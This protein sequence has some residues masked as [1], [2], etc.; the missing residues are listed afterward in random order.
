MSQEKEISSN[1]PAVSFSNV[2]FSYDAKSPTPTI[3]GI[4]FDIHQGEYMCIVGSNGSGKSTISK[5]IV[6]L[7]KP[8]SGEIKIFG[9]ILNNLTIKSIRNNVGIIFQNPDNQFIGLTAEDDIAFGL[10]NNKINSTVMFDIITTAANIVNVQDL[11]KLNASR[12]SGGQKQRVAIASVLAMN[13]KVI[14]FDE[15]TSM[16]DPTSKVELNNLMTMLRDK[17][18]KTIIS[19]THDMEELLRADRVMVIK[20]GTVQKIGKPSEIFED[21]QFLRNNKLNLP[22]T[23]EVSKNLHELNSKVNLTL[24]QD[25]L[26]D[27]LGGL[28]KKK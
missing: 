22:F 6:G 2:V 7:L 5:I 12:L 20:E 21:E 28:C 4:S 10:E 18:S 17:Y 11:L 9:N 27:Q 15:S 24:T 26:V 13:P 14:I 25:K 16:L 23:L 1:I 3:K 19:I 8:K